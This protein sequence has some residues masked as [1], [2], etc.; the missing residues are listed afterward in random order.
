HFKRQ[1]RSGLT[2]GYRLTHSPRDRELPPYSFHLL[3]VND[4]GGGPDARPSLSI[5][6]ACREKLR[7]LRITKHTFDGNGPRIPIKVVKPSIDDDPLFLL[8]IARVTERPEYPKPTGDEVDTTTYLTESRRTSGG[9]T[10]NITFAD[11]W[12]YTNGSDLT[13]FRPLLTG[14]LTR[15]FIKS[16]NVGCGLSSYTV[17]ELGWS[18]HSSLALKTVFRYQRESLASIIPQRNISLQPGP[19]TLSY[20]EERWCNDNPP[21]PNLTS[22]DSVA[23][24]LAR[25][26]VVKREHCKLS[27]KIWPRAPEMSSGWTL[28]GNWLSAEQCLQ[29]N[30]LISIKAELREVEIVDNLTGICQRNFCLLAHEL[31]LINSI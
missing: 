1:R 8:S 7:K 29:Q 13:P 28:T 21:S 22:N 6:S 20:I 16:L 23:F 30:M 27:D 14:Y 10:S 11:I 17:Y 2:S 3:K 15:K 26:C 18:S 12:G 5:G 4:S 9:L 24:V 31:Y 19:I 25:D